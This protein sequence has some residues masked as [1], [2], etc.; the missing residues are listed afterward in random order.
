MGYNTPLEVMMGIH[1]KLNKQKDTQEKKIMEL[2]LQIK[3]LHPCH[4][5][6]VLVNKLEDD[7]E[8]AEN[9]LADIERQLSALSRHKNGGATL[10]NFLSEEN[11]AIVQDELNGTLDDVHC[12]IKRV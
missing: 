4:E 1:S 9:K 7:L 2:T 5:G 3:F 6:D 10:D 8:K 12:E 11:L